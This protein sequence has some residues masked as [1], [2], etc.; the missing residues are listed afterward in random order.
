M[1]FKHEITGCFQL[2][3]FVAAI[4]VFGFAR[5][6]SA[7]EQGGAPPQQNPVQTTPPGAT[8]NGPQLQITSDEAVRLALE[9]NLG[10][11]AARLSPEV[12]AMDLAQTRATYAPI[13]FTNA[14]KNSNSNP[15]SNFLS[16][17]DF[18]TNQGVRSNAGVAQQMRWGGGRYQASID[19]SRNTTSDPTDPFNPRLSS[20]FNFNFTQPLLRNFTIDST[21]QQL[22]LGQKQK[23]IVDVQLQQQI[24]QTTRRVRSAYFDLVGAYGQLDVARQTLELAQKSLKDNQMRVEV[25]TLPPIDIIEAQAEVSR[26][27]EGVI[28]AEA[29]IKTLEDALRTLIMNPSQ[30]DFWTARITPAEQPVLTPQAVDV[31]AAVSNAL[32]NRTDLVQARKQ[33]E[34]TDINLKYARNQRLP[35]V[36]AVLNYGLAGIGGT[37]TI[38]DTSQGFPIPTGSAQRSFG[39][40]LRDIF[41]NEFKTWSLQLQVSYPI[42]QSQAEAAVAQTRLQ[43]QQDVTSLHQLEMLIAT[44][45]RDAARQVETSLKR[46]EA[47]KKAREFAE[48]NL[49]AEQKRM[50][51][52]LSTTFQLLQAQRRL[53]EQRLAE[54]TATID[55]NRALVNLQ[56]VQ[57]VPLQ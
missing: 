48:R 52:G 28:I 4:G 40:A 15:P 54:L 31:A 44:S 16:G 56:A 18:I 36:D 50:T 32:A 27:E 43:R 29:R 9:N 10:I 3:A 5:G 2:V 7:F 53:S 35:N 1:R 49:D 6:V 55:Y 57:T 38:Y 17:N 51:V 45:V 23:E 25:G 8:S 42:G 24:A 41:G 33:L 34:Q 37:R 11:Q 21:R 12:Q 20:N 26:N 22:M 30:P 46:V 39:D 47:T 14:T 19:G 13:L